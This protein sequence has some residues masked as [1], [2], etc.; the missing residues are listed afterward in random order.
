VTITQANLN[1]TRALLARL[2]RDG[3]QVV[4][5]AGWD[6]RDAGGLF[7]PFVG[8]IIHHDAS[9]VRS[10]TWG[11]LGIIVAGRGGA[12]PVSGP[13]A[14]FQIARGVV[15][16]ITVVTAGR[17]NHAGVGGPYL[18]VPK[19]SGNR[20]LVGTEVANDG[21]SEPYSEATTWAIESWGRAVYDLTGQNPVRVIGHNEWAA[22][23]SAHLDTA[24][25]K[26]TGRK[27]DP[28]YSMVWMRGRIV[29]HS[30]PTG[31]EF[32]MDAAATRAFTD[33]NAKLD[34]IHRVE[35]VGDG[36]TVPAS[37]DTHGWNFKGT[38]ERIANLQD[39][40]KALQEAVKQTN[41]KIDQVLAALTP[42]EPTP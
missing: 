38:Y 8:G 36:P 40:L 32:T 5:Q 29:R 27:S 24:L 9:S 16:R 6:R 3:V 1:Q 33:L 18:N 31:Q 7:G 21:V 2:T 10:G 28:R 41:V 19:D 11:A 30:T 23:P 22:S 26:A 12:N 15:P 37:K 25:H 13:L 4:Y 34:G 20:W 14:Q 35:T 39:Q 17:G 42:K